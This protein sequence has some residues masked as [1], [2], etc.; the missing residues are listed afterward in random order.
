VVD[1]EP[2]KGASIVLVGHIASLFF[3]PLGLAIALR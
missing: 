1:Q 3:V 2:A